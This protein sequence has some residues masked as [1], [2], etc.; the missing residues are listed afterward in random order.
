[1]QTV[2]LSRPRQRALVVVVTA[3]LAWASIASIA[4]AAADKTFSATVGPAPLVAGAWYGAAERAATPIL[5][6]I[7]NISNQAQ[8]G[9]ANVTVPDGLVLTGASVPLPATATS[10]NPP[11]IELRNLDL[12]PGESVV[13]GVSAQVECAPNPSHSYEWTFTVKQAN[14]FNGTPGNNLAPYGPTTSSVAGQCGLEFTDEPRSSEKSPVPITSKI[15]DPTGPAVKVSV[16][17]AEGISYTPWWSGSISIALGD[18]PS[19]GSAL[20]GGI[21]T[22]PTTTGAA[23]FAP[24]IN[25]SAS[26]YSLLADAEGTSGTPAEGTSAAVVESASF[27]I[28]D[29]AKICTTTT[30]GCF[31]EA[32]IDQKTGARVD[33]SAGGAANDLVILSIADPTIELSCTGYAF[34]SDIV[35][36]DVTD[37]TGGTS[38]QR[39]KIT[40][41]TLAAAS[42]TKSASKY[43]IC[44]DASESGVGVL[45]A[46]CTNKTPASQ[47]CVVSKALDKAKN[48]V[49]VIHT[50]PGDPRVAM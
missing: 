41:L 35:V 34:D 18:D 31:A 11:V 7:T 23:T 3:L 46:A 47:P 4:S 2:R 40:T 28:V 1:M 33:A 30:D 9:S 36:F 43:Q 42:V 48:L 26:H 39:S 20:L 50:P 13:V 19:G 16:V 17:D 14:D 49:V 25:V 10:A 44:F 21:L 32:G 38:A 24:D 22:K 8:L 37:S 29:D 6:T 12:Q 27:N 15:Y 5:L 45:L